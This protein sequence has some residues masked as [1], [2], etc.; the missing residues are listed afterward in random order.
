MKVTVKWGVILGVSVIVWTLVIHFLGFYTTNLAA[1][2][3][4]DVVATILPI[5]AIV[6]ALLERR[7]QLGRGLKI[8]DSL[9]VGVLTGVVSIPITAGFLWFYHNYMNPQ[10]ADLLI[11]YKN[12][13]MA[14][15]GIAPEVIQLADQAQRAGSTDI[16]QLLGA[17]IGTPL[18]SLVI[19][20]VAHIFV[21]RQPSPAAK[22]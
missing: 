10:W 22:G 18:I 7:R 13:Q 20:L 12:Q 8:K 17:L 6:M 1:G 19:S 3:K 5:A 15:A 14:A 11:A 16:A 9:A 21:R 4:A 2:Q